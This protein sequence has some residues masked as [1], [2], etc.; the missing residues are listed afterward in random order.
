[1]AK[2]ERLP[3]SERKLWAFVP[4]G[5]WI[6][7]IYLGFCP[8]LKSDLATVGQCPHFHISTILYQISSHLM[9]FDAVWQQ[10][11]HA[12]YPTLPTFEKISL[13]LLEGKKDR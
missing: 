5:S 13:K 12:L 2:S 7:P 6:L 8:L 3:K 10:N 1:V 4:N 11:A 9:Q